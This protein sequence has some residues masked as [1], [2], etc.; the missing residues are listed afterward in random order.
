MRY[1]LDTNILVFLVLDQ[2]ELSPMVRD[3]VDDYSSMLCTSAVCIVEL[4]QLYRIRK[5]RPKYK[6][7]GALL[8]ALVDKFSLEILPFGEKQIKVLTELCV[9]P[10]H[11]D[12]FDHAVISHAIADRLTLVSSDRKFDQYRSQKLS[13]VFNER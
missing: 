4:L 5:I 11:N 9:A 6:T 10:G 13:F 3:I 8:A 2:E 1:L 12:P 7:A